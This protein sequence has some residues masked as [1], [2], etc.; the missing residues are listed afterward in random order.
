MIRAFLAREYDLDEETAG[1]E[2]PDN[3]INVVM[4]G[5]SHTY[6][7]WRRGAKRQ[8]YGI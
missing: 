2:Y 7:T 1:R 3:I 4:C 8:Q 6:E 5:D